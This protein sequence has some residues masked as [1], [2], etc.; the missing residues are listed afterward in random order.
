MTDSE[1]LSLFRIA[2]GVAH[3]AFPNTTPARWD[4]THIIVELGSEK[5]IFGIIKCENDVRIGDGY[6]FVL[7]RY[8]SEQAL[9]V[10]DSG[11]NEIKKEFVK[12]TFEI[13]KNQ[14]ILFAQLI[15]MGY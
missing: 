13:V 12:E 15:D 8:S 1:L 10:S 14:N 11:L 5:F 4:S 3:D 7:N 2:K 6:S 9:E